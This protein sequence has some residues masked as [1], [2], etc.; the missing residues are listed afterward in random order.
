MNLMTRPKKSEA[1]AKRNVR[2][3]SPVNVYIDEDLRT[4]VDAFI[5][6][7]NLKDEHPASL[8]STVEASLRQYLKEKG[9]WPPKAT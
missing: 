9:F 8:R 4:A 2:S 6:A 3:G 1:P 5:S 7:H